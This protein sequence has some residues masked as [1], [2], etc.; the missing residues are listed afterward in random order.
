MDKSKIIGIIFGFALFGLAI[1]FGSKLQFES[2]IIEAI[3]AVIGLIVFMVVTFFLFRAKRI[4]LFVALGIL[5]MFANY[6]IIFIFWEFHPQ[7]SIIVLPIVLLI[8]IV[9]LGIGVFR[10]VKNVLNK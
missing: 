10:M 2:A 4:F 1:C 6:A 9:F 3:I 5:L 7:M 8:S